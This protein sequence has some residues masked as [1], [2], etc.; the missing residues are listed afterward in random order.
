MSDLPEEQIYGYLRLYKIPKTNTGTVAFQTAILIQREIRTY[1]SCNVN[2]HI[3]LVKIK[4][5]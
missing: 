2:L 5:S 4:L 3:K 1:D